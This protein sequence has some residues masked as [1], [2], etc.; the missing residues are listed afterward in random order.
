MPTKSLIEELP[1][2]VREG[3]QE[4]QRIMERLSSSTRIGLQ[5]NE[6]VL[7]SKDTSG[8]WKGRNEQVINKEWMNRLIYGDN[9]LAM[10]ALLAGDEAT[11]LPSL[12]GKVDLIYIDPPFDSKADYRTKI[13]LPGIDIEQKPTVIE[14]FAYSDTWQDGTVSYLKMLY[15]RL[16]LMRELLSDKGSIY[17]HIDWHV[18]H[19]V[20]TVMDEIFGK[21]NFT[22]EIVWA[23]GS[24]SGGRAASAKFVKM[25]EIIF[26]YAKDY[27]R[28]TE[29]K[30]YLPYSE[31]YIKDWFKYSDEE[32]R[33]YQRRMRGK[34]STGEIIWERQYLDESKGVPCSTVWTDIQQVYADPRAYKKNQSQHSEITTYDTQKP[35]RLL[36]RIIEHSSNEGDL[37]CDFFGG[38]GTTAAVAERLGRRW[39]TTDIGKPAI[40]VMRK[41]FIDNNAR[42]FLY[43]CIGDYTKELYDTNKKYK[44][45]GDLTQIVMQLYGAIPFN[46]EQISERNWGYIKSEK[47]LVFVDSPRKWTSAATLRRAFN[48]KNNLLGGGWEKVVVLGWNFSFDISSAIQQY[49]KDID[50]LVIPERLLS[51]LSKKGYEK[52]IRDKSIRFSTLQY[53]MIRPIEVRPIDNEQE[54]IIVMLDNY[55]LLSPDNIPLDDKDKGKLQE[56]MDADPLAL[57][58]YW[59]IDPDY[60]GETFRSKW[61]DYRENT[62]NDSD[63]LHCIY[64]ASLVV[65]KK[66]Q[67]TVCVKAVDVF[68]FESV[69]TEIVQ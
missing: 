68:G 39:I 64:R 55:I 20:K 33:M 67:R 61:Q 52:V 48:A 4:A 62:E 49:K 54:E 50:V 58:E 26:H 15:P 29:E 8:L 57:I 44:Q 53:L 32:G 17:V 5:T 9:L 35:E 47:T 38:S 3:K 42:P 34:T 37:V 56:V 31:K 30:V 21:D 11:G 66:A 28:R 46:K 45:I 25:H 12:R 27:Q 69:V 23:Y 63:P 2:I 10:Q 1:K 43:Q 7:P 65:P 59:S 18:G 14:Q 41:R 51:E 24:P 36:S 22:D 19:Y 13:N 60:D 40:L 6:L 16:V